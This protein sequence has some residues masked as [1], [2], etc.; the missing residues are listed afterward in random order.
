MA[1]LNV[2]CSGAQLDPNTR[3]LSETGLRGSLEEISRFE[4]LCDDKADSVREE[5]CSR[6]ILLEQDVYMSSNAVIMRSDL[7]GV[8]CDP[9][10]S[11]H[12][13][14]DLNMK[15]T[16]PEVADY[17]LG[18]VWHVDGSDIDCIYIVYLY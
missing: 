11:P 9:I 6:M 7:S 4:T 16:K 2:V 10:T 14:L 12:T 8:R 13:T 1:D 3:S 15:M 5:D 17:L 18:L